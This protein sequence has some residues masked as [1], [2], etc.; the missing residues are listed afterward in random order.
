MLDHIDLEHSMEAT[1][2][3]EEREK[4]R[5]MLLS[6]ISHDFKT[7]LAGIIGALSVHRSLGDKL[8]PQ[9]RAELIEAAI[10]EAQ[11]LDS[12]I[13]NILDMT[14]LESGNIRFKQEW[15]GMQTHDRQCRQAACSHR[16]PPAQAGGA[17]DARRASGLYMD[18]MM[19]EQVLQNLLD[20]AC[21][22]TPPGT[23]HRN[24]LRRGG[25]QRCAA[26]RC[27][28]MGRAC[29][30]KSSTAYS[31]NMHACIRRIFRWRVPASGFPSAKPSWKRRAAALPPPIIRRAA[32]CLRC[33]CRNGATL[34]QLA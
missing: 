10:E 14:R 33:A 27:A 2:I 32:P 12:F 24:S 20:N 23:P 5:S 8:M 9:K 25:R 28:I 26:A 21:K 22:Y 7:P 16:L 29:P 4:L 1:R 30:P 3:R 17:S 18:V 6:S 11:R 15:H 19:T 13:T 31:T 34:V